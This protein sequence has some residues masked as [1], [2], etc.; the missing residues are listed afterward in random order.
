MSQE[1]ECLRR[2]VSAAV[3][4]VFITNRVNLRSPD[5][6]QPL[7][8][9]HFIAIITC[10]TSLTLSFIPPCSTATP[11]TSSSSTTPATDPTTPS[12]PPASLPTALLLAPL[13]A[14]EP[15]LPALCCI[16]T[17]TP[18]RYPSVSTSPPSDV[19]CARHGQEPL[20][21]G[22]NRATSGSGYKQFPL[23]PLSLSLSSID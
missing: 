19:A 3:C 7:H 10:Y 22:G 15:S 13:L 5:L 1:C 14:S 23:P 2:G 4:N 9:I 11:F 20:T 17:A 6:L 18:Q 8:F 16:L 21:T 12:P